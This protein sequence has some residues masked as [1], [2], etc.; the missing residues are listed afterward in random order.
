[1]CQAL[2]V[3]SFEVSLNYTKLAMLPTKVFMGKSKTNQQTRKSSCVNA[4]G[5][6]PAA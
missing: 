3:S 1:M 4:R 6:P 5:I 2:Q